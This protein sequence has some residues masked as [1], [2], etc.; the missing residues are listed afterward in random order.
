MVHPVRVESETGNILRRKIF[1]K[2]INIVK[3]IRVGNAENHW[4]D[5][6]KKGNL[7]VSF[8]GDDL[9]L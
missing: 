5:F 2:N 3:I 9:L 4:P 8:L 6:I 1:K 7:V